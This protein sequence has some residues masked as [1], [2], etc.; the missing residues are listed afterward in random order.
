MQ[1]QS[2]Q[3]LFSPNLI[4]SFYSLEKY[5]IHG[6]RILS[7]SFQV[8]KLEG[9]ER[10]S[11]AEHLESSEISDSEMADTANTNASSNMDV[12]EDT[13]TYSPHAVASQPPTNE[14]SEDEDEDDPSDI[15]MVPMADMLNARYGCE[16]VC[17]LHLF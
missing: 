11:D 6:N 2:C 5:H 8:S 16:N 9:E 7:R 10:A 4:P 15:A 12:D 3:D 13:L 14:D 17:K 1:D